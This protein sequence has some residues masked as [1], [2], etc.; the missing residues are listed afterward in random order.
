VVEKEGGL[1]QGKKKNAGLGRR[2]RPGM[3]GFR[4]L[5]RKG[6]AQKGNT[7]DLGG[8]EQRGFP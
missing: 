7:K 8:T 4:I 1:A 6:L 5:L 2:R 3:N